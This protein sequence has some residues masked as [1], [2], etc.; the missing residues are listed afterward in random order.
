MYIGIDIGGMSI[1]AGAVAGDGK[2]LEKY[3]VKTPFD[4]KDALCEAILESVRGLLK[5]LPGGEMPEGIG[6]GAPGVC[7][8]ENGILV[9]ANNI[10]YDNAN[11]REYLNRH[12]DVPVLIENDANCA[13]LGE[14][15]ASG[16]ADNFV[17]ITL[18]TG[19]GGGIVINRSLYLGT[20]GAG[21]ELGH[22]VTHADGRLC[23]CGRRGCWEAYA[24]VSA[25]I[26]LTRAHSAEIGLLEQT[27]IDGRTA[28]DLARAGN[29]A[30]QKVRDMWIGEVAA[31]VVNMINI[32][33]PDE[34]VIGGAISNEGD[35]LLNPI[36]EAAERDG[37][38]EGQES[39][40]PKTQINISRLKSDGGIIGAAFLQRNAQQGR[41]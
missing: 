29:A 22:H 20:N 7:D 12:F 24:S 9:Y 17:F 3:A 32:F 15:Y 34:I 19:V 23:N 11:I 37:Y 31:G 5:K 6:I 33:Q 25:L 1:K 30:A 40:Q 28:F 36:R 41:D 26:E 10:K 14:Y 35:T 8:R 2:I 18:G 27:E 13:A 4:D 21:A 38:A 39:I 16:S